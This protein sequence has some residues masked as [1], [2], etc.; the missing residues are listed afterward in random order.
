MMQEFHHHVQGQKP[1]QLQPVHEN[2]RRSL[3]MADLLVSRQNSR[4]NSNTGIFGDRA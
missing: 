4:G 2:S 3:Q 1:Q